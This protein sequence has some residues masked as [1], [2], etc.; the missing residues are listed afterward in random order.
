MSYRF[1]TY[2][3]TFKKIYKHY[4]SYAS[5]SVGICQRYICIICTILVGTRFTIIKIINKNDNTSDLDYK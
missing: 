5:I 4:L 1:T 3:K 2:I